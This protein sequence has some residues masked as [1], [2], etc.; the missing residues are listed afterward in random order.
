MSTTLESEKWTSYH[1]FI[2]SFMSVVNFFT[3]FNIVYGGFILNNVANSFGISV[4]LLPIITSIMALGIFP[5]I[6][7]QN[8]ADIYG[9]KKTLF[10]ISNL[11]YILGYFYI[12]SPNI[13]FFIIFGFISTCFGINLINV[14]ISEEI[15]AK[16]RGTAIGVVQGIGMSGSL[17][18]AYLS[19]FLA[20]SI[21]MW[22]YIHLAVNIPG[23]IIFSIL[24]LFMK[25]T[26]RFQ[27]QKLIEGSFEKED[28]FQIFAIFQRKYLKIFSLSAGLMFIVQFIYLTIKRY[29]KP[30]LLD[31]RG[32]LGFNDAVVGFWMIFIYLGS[33][34]G[35]YLSGWLSDQIGR[36]KTIYI[37]ASVY[38]VST[39]FFV[40]L[41][42]E[43]GIFLSLL[44]VNVSFAIFI[45][46]V[47]IYAVEFFS[48]KERATGLGWLTI[49]GNTPWIFANLVVFL[50]VSTFSWGETFLYL[51][52]LPLLLII[53]TY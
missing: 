20:L 15:P 13:I 44:G 26:K 47:Q 25:E 16:F 40:I 41:Q 52:F 51:S 12:L 18:A 46:V 24:C 22:R 10:V 29:Y 37:S 43:L 2:I 36:K 42:N 35:Y 50:L 45:V 38:F 53:L 3:L 32:Y 21:N 31:E 11:T 5:V 17:L 4:T 9:R 34:C 28:R 27:E 48:T 19:T 6:F 8:L 49:I 23:Q 30:F 33:I 39:L 14:I 1:T 7:V